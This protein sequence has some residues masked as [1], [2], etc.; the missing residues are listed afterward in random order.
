MVARSSKPVTEKLNK[1][2]LKLNQTD[3]LSNNNSKPN[4]NSTQ[5]LHLAVLPFKAQRL[6]TSNHPKKGTKHIK[7]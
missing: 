5:L 7:N 4:M 2:C 3:H 1:R 6:L